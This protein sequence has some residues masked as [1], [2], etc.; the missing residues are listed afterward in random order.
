M[1]P[2][3]KT[4]K[5]ATRGAITCSPYCIF[6]ILSYTVEI[7]LPVEDYVGVCAISS[8][9]RFRTFDRYSGYNK[10]TKSPRWVKG[11]IHDRSHG[12]PKYYSSVKI[13]KDGGL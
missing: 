3:V 1:M 9:G 13:V 5:G 6:M 12:N 10:G 7:W 2:G 8:F 11:Q 4:H